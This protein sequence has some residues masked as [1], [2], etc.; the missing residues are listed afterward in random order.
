MI[1]ADKGQIKVEGT[2]KEILNDLSAISGA[3][4]GEFGK[5]AVVEAVALG[6]AFLSGKAERID[7][8][9]LNDV[10]KQLTDANDDE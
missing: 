8:T 9:N 4:G 10:L 7:L 3:L 5:E 6:L 1:H 2:G